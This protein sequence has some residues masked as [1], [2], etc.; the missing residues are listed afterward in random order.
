MNAVLCV[1]GKEFKS[2]FK[3]AV[4]YVF[5]VVFLVLTGWA[6]FFMAGFF[7]SRAA[8]LARG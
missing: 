7:E 6:F 3:T 4:A 8:T 1:A 2:Y 5:L